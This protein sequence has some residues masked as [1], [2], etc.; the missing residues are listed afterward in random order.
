MTSIMA[1]LALVATILFL[2]PALAIL[3]IPALGAILVGAAI[4]LI[5]IAALRQLW[6]ISRVEFVFAMIALWAPIWLGVLN[7]VIIAI[8]A[9]LVYLLGRT[10]YPRDA[11]LGLIPGRDG[12]FK[13]HRH[14][15]A[16][17]EPGLAIALV[18]GSVLFF[19]ADYVRERMG[20]V[21]GGLPEG[22]RWFVLDASAVTQVDSSAAAMFDGL[23]DDI[24][25]RGL[26]FGLAE[27]HADV[28][29]LLDRAGVLARIGPAMI[30][31]D[32]GDALRAWRAQ[33]GRA[34]G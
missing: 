10:M 24:E 27:L 30:F 17:P 18:Q 2:G 19:N 23:I 7:G 6:K 31:D 4:G 29:A 8:A 16:Q 20:A 21:A 34:E 33:A 9:T 3:P 5:D 15:E 13:L 14:P 26:R 11:L 28:R 32:V 1:A 22:T 25:A 12:F